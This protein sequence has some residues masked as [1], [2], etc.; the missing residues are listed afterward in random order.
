MHFEPVFYY[1]VFEGLDIDKS[2]A[3]LLVELVRSGKLIITG[4]LL[5]PCTQAVG[6]RNF[7]NVGHDTVFHI[8]NCSNEIINAIK[9]IKLKCSSEI[10]FC[11]VNDN[12][13]NYKLYVTEMFGCTPQIDYIFG[14]HTTIF[15]EIPWCGDRTGLFYKKPFTEIFNF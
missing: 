4:S 11:I 8:I 3:D 9:T 12:T 6:T 1:E 5:Q 7:S 10:N 2:M 15:S 13:F 14:V